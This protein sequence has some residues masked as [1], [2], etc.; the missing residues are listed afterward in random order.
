[1][2]KKV[3]SLLNQE[4]ALRS[5]FPESYIKRNG[6]YKLTWI[7]E[8]TPTPLSKNYKVKLTYTR[9]N[10]PK[11][12]VLEPTLELA[13][14]TTSLPHV[15]SNS[16]QRLCLYYPKFKEWTPSQYFV[17]TIIPWISEWLEHYEIWLVT[18][19][20]HGGGIEHKSEEEK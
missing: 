15:Y 12:Y 11:V 2:S 9:G 6:D 8:I 10:G 3:I 17:N 4:G 5:Y 7:H 20:W 13:T 19:E 18:G 16:E 1:M 14:G